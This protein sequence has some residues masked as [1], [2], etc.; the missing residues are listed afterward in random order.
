MLWMGIGCR[1]HLGWALIGLIGNRVHAADWPQWRGPNR[2]GATVGVT[3]P[4][5]WPK[6]ITQLWEV[7]IGRGL[8]SPI[9]VGRRIYVHSR[10]EPDEV[11]SCLNIEDGTLLWSG[12]YPA[13]WKVQPGAGDDKGP[14][15]TPTF[16]G[17]RVYTLG[18][19]GVLTCWDAESGEVKWRWNPPPGATGV[20]PQYGAAL[21][22]LVEDG[23]VYAHGSG[24]KQTAL[25]AF[26]ADTGEMKWAWHG[27]QPAYASPILVEL[28]GQR[29]I[30]LL[31]E[32]NLAGLSPAD[33]KVLWKRGL[34]PRNSYENIITP[35]CYKDLII[36]SQ[37]GFREINAVRVVRDG[38]VFRAED[39]WSNNDH[40]L[41]E[42][43]PVV[44]GDLLI[45][46]S[47]AK[48]GHLFC[49]DAGTGKNLWEYGNGLQSNVPL[50]NAG[51]VVLA[52]TKGL[53]ITVFRPNAERYDPV[54][55]WQGPRSAMSAGPVFLGDRILLLDSG[56]LRMM[57]IKGQ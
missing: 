33:G 32:G 55:E 44:A 19:R 29:Q 18:V 50:V 22:P 53:R 13:P 4:A 2:D 21:S 3:L 20:I 37:T 43:T 56:G 10:N 36:Y 30:V 48:G 8:S 57:G 54:T 7:K 46:L 47:H 12:R 5:T 42:C 15:S 38:G 9:V 17:G 14:H 41:D 1:R 24:E 27:A 49:I 40:R 25:A 6:T 35:V 31:T 16:K 52:V 26:D 34:R 45:G 51:S 28:S 23:I 11:V 39:V